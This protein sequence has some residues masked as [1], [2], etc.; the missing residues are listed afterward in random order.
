MKRIQLF[1][2]PG[3]G[4]E[5]HS[6]EKLV[7]LVRSNG[8]ECRYSSTTESNWKHID[9]NCDFV[10]VAGGDGTIK[11][12]ATELLKSVKGARKAIALLPSGT[13]NNIAT[14]LGITGSQEEIIHSWKEERRKKYDIGLLHD[15]HGSKFFMEGFGY[16]VFPLLIKKMIKVEAESGKK[17]EEGLK[18][19]LEMLHEIIL[20]FRG[21]RCTLKADGE[22]YSGKYLMVE[23]MNTRFIGPRLE[24]APDGDPGD[25]LLNVVLVPELQRYELADYVMRKINGAEV[26]FTFPTIRAKK[27]RVDWNGSRI[28]IDDETMKLDREMEVKV[29]VEPGVFDFL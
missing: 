18:A 15:V 28:H 13:A 17:G 4:D 12:I 7:S 25:G 29:D 2:N 5:D 23:I 16:G 19:A 9:E 3:A 10:A 1:H 11:E 24:L 27:I 8:Y 22:K 20:S 14:T 6:G 26:P 21:R